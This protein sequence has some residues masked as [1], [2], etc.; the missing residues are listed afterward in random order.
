M[1]ELLARHTTFG[2]GGPA[3]VWVA[4]TSEDELIAEVAAADAAGQPVLILGG[5][6]NVLIADAGFEG[7]VVHTGSFRGVQVDDVAAC[8][9][10]FLT[11]AAGEPWDAFVAA[12][13]AQGQVG[14]EALAGIPGLVGATPVQNVGAYGQEVSQVI[15]RV[16]TYD[17]RE[18]AIRTFAAIECGFG[19][20]D[21]LFKREP[22]RWVVLSVSFQ[23]R[24][25][26]LAAPIRYVELARALG[27]EVGERAAITE[28]RRAV[29]EL[30]RSK[31]MVYD[32]DD[33]D[34]WSAGSFFTNPVVAELDLIP[35]GAPAYPQPDGRVKTSAAWLIEHAGF[36][37]GYGHGLARLSAKHTLALTNRGS[38][39]AADVVALAR[40]VR[41]GVEKAYG[42]HL[43]AEPVLVG[44]SLDD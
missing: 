13:V 19:Y 43:V 35:D 9:G 4:P 2:V 25:G 42:I 30:R 44:L 14:I 34:T 41:A 29:L 26:D 40:E 24:L 32:P 28:V 3:A 1:T 33:H 23:F 11:V 15:A 7:K 12:T 8:S 36:N 39:K 16:R 20:R 18:R 38:A 27:I 6:S 37:R 10:A 21:S 31:G 22:G 17:R 5:G